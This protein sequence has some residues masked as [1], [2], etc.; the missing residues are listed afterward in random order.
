[1]ENN[2]YKALIEAVD[3]Y[4]SCAKYPDLSI[5]CAI[6]G[7]DPPEEGRGENYD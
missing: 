7:I 2:I 3:R 5:V 4:I 1:M 6:L